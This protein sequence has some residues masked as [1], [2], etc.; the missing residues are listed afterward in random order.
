MIPT[1]IAKKIKHVQMGAQY[2]ELNSTCFT[3][4]IRANKI[5]MRECMS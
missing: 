2:A 5:D 4:S 1:L 3:H